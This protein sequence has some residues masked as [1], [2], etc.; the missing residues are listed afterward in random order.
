MNFPI[1]TAVDT[2]AEIGEK[3][4]DE[5]VDVAA[6][7]ATSVVI[8]AVGRSVR[9][10]ATTRILT[11]LAVVGVLALAGWFI[12]KKTGGENNRSDTGAPSRV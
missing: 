4:L 3:V 9:R 11:V 7:V 8:P 5:A 6:E 1:D 10:L 2:A 12:V